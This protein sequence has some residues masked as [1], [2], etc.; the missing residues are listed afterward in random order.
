MSEP[1]ISIACV[2]NVYIRQMHFA[3]AGDTEVGH[4]HPFDHVSFLSRGSIRLV[5]N[6]ESRDFA[7]PQL[8]VI[9]KEK[10]H[11]IVALEDNSEV[12]CI[13]A[14]RDAG[15]DILPSDSLITQ[16]EREAMML[17]LRTPE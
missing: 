9:R 7:A 12:S 8:I 11:E 16:A 15:G 10:Q 1:N 4:S 6:G 14:L 2:S 17:A 13:H 3:K 5:V